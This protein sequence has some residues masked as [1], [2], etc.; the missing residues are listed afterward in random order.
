MKKFKY[1]IF[2]LLAITATIAFA[3]ATD[4]YISSQGNIVIKTAASK[5]VG[6]QGSLYTKQTGE[7][8]IGNSSPGDKLDV[9]GAIKSR[10][11]GS[12]YNYHIFDTTGVTNRGSIYSGPLSKWSTKSITNNINL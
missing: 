12:G 1:F 10:A 4:K 8:G 7:V 6:I 11:D 9:S 3:A 5:T 2:V